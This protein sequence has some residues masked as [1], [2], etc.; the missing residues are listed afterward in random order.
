M[1]IA[2]QH[3]HG[4]GMAHAST[5]SRDLIGQENPDCAKDLCSSIYTEVLKG[6]VAQ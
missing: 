5:D 4:K 6:Q 2:M 1:V 3:M